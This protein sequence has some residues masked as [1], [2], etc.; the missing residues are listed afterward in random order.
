VELIQGA[1]ISLFGAQNYDSIRGQGFDHFETD[2]FQ[3]CPPDAWP[4]VIRPALSDR[5]GS[6]GFKGTPKGRANWSFDMWEFAGKTPGWSRYRFTTIE[7]GLVVPEEVALARAHM[8]ERTFRQEYEASFESSGSLVYYT[9]DDDSIAQHSFDPTA[10]TV[11]TWD[12]NRTDIKPMCC[13]LVQSTNGQPIGGNDTTYAMTKEFVFPNTN[14]DE[15]CKTVDKWLKEQGF[16]GPLFVAGDYAGSRRESSASHSDYQIIAHHFGNYPGYY[17]KNPVS[18]PTRSIEDRVASL[19]SLFRS[20]DGRRR[21]WVDPSC[22]NT[23]EDLR[24]TEW[25]EN[26]VGLNDDHGRRT[27][28]SDALSYFGYNFHDISRRRPEYH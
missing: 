25:K 6:A 1:R 3:D 8:D 17:R 20:M 2:E 19:N 21:L 27:D 4:E 7:G 9:F 5:R 15:M 24:R 16:S 23:I 14:T 13:L 12:F 11:M 10:P 28:E 26:G 22:K 18:K